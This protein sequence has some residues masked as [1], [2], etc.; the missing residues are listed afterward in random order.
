[1]CCQ[2][3]CNSKNL[4]NWYLLL[5]FCWHRSFSL[6]VYEVIANLHFLVTGLLHFKEILTLYYHKGIVIGWY[7]FPDVWFVNLFWLWKYGI[8]SHQQGYTSKTPQPSFL[9]ECWLEEIV[10]ELA[11]CFDTCHFLYTSSSKERQQKLLYLSLFDKKLRW[12]AGQL[13]FSGQSVG[14]SKKRPREKER[15]RVCGF[16][17][18][19]AYLTNDR[20]IKAEPVSWQQEWRAQ[21][22]QEKEGGREER[23]KAT[24][25]LHTL[26]FRERAMMEW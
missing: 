25:Y 13:V 19:S 20:K 16:A 12:Q 26:R 9:K 6:S 2:Y 7:Q 8:T 21:R 5:G 24:L 22:R 17:C 10:G 1:M 3:C 23:K 14:E 18:V 15:K 11:E 4:R